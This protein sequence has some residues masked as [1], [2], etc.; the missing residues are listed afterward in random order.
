MRRMEQPT[1]II[2]KEQSH[3]SFEGQEESTRYGWRGI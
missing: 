3:P 2:V 1:E